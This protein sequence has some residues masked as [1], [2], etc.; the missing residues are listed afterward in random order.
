[1]VHLF[2][3]SSFRS[4]PISIVLFSAWVNSRAKVRHIFFCCQE[5]WP[6]SS[7]S[8]FFCQHSILANVHGLPFK[9]GVFY[10]LVL[11]EKCRMEMMAWSTKLSSMRVKNTEKKLK[12]RLHFIYITDHHS[13]PWWENAKW[14]NCLHFINGAT[15]AEN[16][17]MTLATPQI[18][19]RAEKKSQ[20][21]L[22]LMLSCTH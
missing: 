14:T 12:A 8:C 1:M 3:D 11:Y 16:G 15:E 6:G 4:F 10:H 17:N 7:L 5:E 2:C 22:V 20:A 21:F 19:G 9:E 13:Y 18:S